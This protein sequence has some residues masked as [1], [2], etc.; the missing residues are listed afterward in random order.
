MRCR[1]QNSLDPIDGAL[2]RDRTRREQAEKL[3]GLRQRYRS[4]TPRERDVMNH[5]IAGM[6]NKQSAAELNIVEKT[7]KFHRANIM[8]KMQADSLAELVRMAGDLGLL[9]PTI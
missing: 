7:I 5:V 1:G 3:A 2:K 6:L 8:A 4:L 9:R